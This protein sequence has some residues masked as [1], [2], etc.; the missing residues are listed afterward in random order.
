MIEIS[1]TIGV[2]CDVNKNPT[3][4]TDKIRNSS[5]VGTWVLRVFQGA[6]AG[7]GAIL[8][9]VSGGVLCVLFGIYQPLMALFAHPIRTLKTRYRFFI[10]IFIGA[11]LGFLVLARLVEWLF[12]TSS[13]LALSLFIGLIAGTLPSLFK[14]GGKHGTTRGTWTAFAVS[15]I[16]LFT[17]LSYLQ[18][19]TGTA[20]TPNG[21]WFLMCGVVWGFSL[22][23]P[24]LSS[25]SIL[26]F[27]G[28]YEPMAAGI[29]NLDFSVILPLGAG[30]AATVLLSARLVHYLFEHHHALMYHLILGVV[31]A[32]TLLIIPTNFT[33]IKD[34]VIALVSFVTGFALAWGM[35][36][37]GERIAEA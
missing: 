4:E 13:I 21:W 5:S 30:I 36:R 8:P 32:S 29:A 27:I 6:M 17:G 31:I 1:K 15:L 16:V 2:R 7:G 28:L 25:S 23:I 14:D 18:T 10:P 33:G 11:G 19:H 9:G 22:V 35:D 20:I 37:Y 12:R 26:I 3:K 34:L 24:G